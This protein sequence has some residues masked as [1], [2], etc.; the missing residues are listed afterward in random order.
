MA[1][2]ELREIRYDAEREHKGLVETI[3]EKAI[4]KL[5]LKE[6]VERMDRDKNDL[7][8]RQPKKSLGSLVLVENT[9]RFAFNIPGGL[10]IRRGDQYLDIHVPP[11]EEDE[12][13]PKA[14]QKSFRLLAAYIRYHQ[15]EQ[16]YLIGITYE[17]LAKVSRRYGFTIANIPIP[18]EI[19]AGIERVFDRYRKRQGKQIKMGKIQLVYQETEKF[20]AK[21][22]QSSTT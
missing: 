16:R 6:E 15:L 10:Q 5:D 7:T 17:Q 21:F 20:L 9:A 1:R 19:T 11:L 8:V 13:S 18:A 14:I 2:S 4:A 22:T 3:A 12:S